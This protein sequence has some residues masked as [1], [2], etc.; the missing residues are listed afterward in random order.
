MEIELRYGSNPHQKQARVV[1]EGGEPL[2][3]LNGAASFINVL[4]ALGAW[5]LAKE[6]AGARASQFLVD[7]QRG[8]RVC[9]L[10]A[11]MQVILGPVQQSQLLDLHPYCIAARTTT[12]FFS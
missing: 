3:V 4:D 9:L 8:R 10:P 2:R 11:Q 5:P 1:F 6:F 12:K 7:P